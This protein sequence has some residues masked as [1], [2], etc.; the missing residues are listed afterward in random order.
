LI[1]PVHPSSSATT[2]V[3]T[4]C[5]ELLALTFASYPDFVV[6]LDISY[7]KIFIFYGKRSQFSLILQFSMACKRKL[8]GVTSESS[9]LKALPD[10]KE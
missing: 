9:E 8:A 4:F 10:R 1:L 2:S 6:I 7:F 5:S 3:A